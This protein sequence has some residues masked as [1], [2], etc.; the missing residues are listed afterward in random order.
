MAQKQKR[1]LR[2]KYRISIINEDTFEEVWRSRLSRFNVIALMF[3]YAVLV[4]GASISLVIFT[5]LKEYI[6][7]YPD[8]NVSNTIVENY[9][10]ADSLQQKVSQHERFYS[11][12]HA[13]MSGNIPDDWHAQL[14]STDS[15]GSNLIYL[16]QFN[17]DPSKND[18]LFRMEFEEE[19][20]YNLSMIDQLNQTVEADELLLVVPIKGVITNDFDPA[21]GHFGVDIVAEEN[22]KVMAVAAGTIVLSEWTIDGGYVVQVQ[23]DKNLISIYKHNSNLLKNTGDKVKAGEAIAIIGNTGEL[24]FGTHLHLELWEDGTPIDPRNHII[25]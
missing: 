9:L 7:G 12:I 6:P 3:F 5:P 4:V 25:F 8:A 10:L 18:S 21:A 24:S 13:I 14:D 1:K 19:E 11:N 2:Y 15:V 20:R 17:L 16:D 22:E 23:H